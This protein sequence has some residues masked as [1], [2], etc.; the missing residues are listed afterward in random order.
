MLICIV[1]FFY[2]IRRKL[3]YEE[4]FVSVVAPLLRIV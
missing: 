2:Y 1:R 3:D 4:L